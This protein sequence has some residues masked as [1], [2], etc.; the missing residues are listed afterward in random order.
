MH[1]NENICIHKLQKSIVEMYPSQE[2]VL[3]VIS[4]VKL[5]MNIR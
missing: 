5:R 4:M 3:K 1:I 2:E